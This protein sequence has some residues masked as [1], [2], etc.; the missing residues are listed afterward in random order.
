VR[1]YN[2]RAE[3]PRGLFIG[4][5]AEGSAVFFPLMQRLTCTQMR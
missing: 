3:A 4:I 1:A 5:E 2:Q